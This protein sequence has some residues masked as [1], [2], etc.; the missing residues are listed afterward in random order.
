[1]VSTFGPGSMLLKRKSSGHSYIDRRAVVL[2]RGAAIYYHRAMPPCPSPTKPR[3]TTTPSLAVALLR[4]AG[5]AARNF[6]RLYTNRRFEEEAQFARRAGEVL[7]ARSL[8]AME[9]EM[10][11]H[12][13]V[14]WI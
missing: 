2:L 3:R 9:R 4:G 11:E 10:I 14:A 5:K 1:M 8:G 12:Q 6:L 13:R 7:V